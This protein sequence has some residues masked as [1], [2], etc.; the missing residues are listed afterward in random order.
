MKT[1][2]FALSAFWML[3]LASPRAEAES[4]RGSYA[5][6]AEVYEVLARCDVND[7]WETMGSYATNEEALDIVKYVRLLGCEAFI[8]THPQTP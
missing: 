4:F 7:P 8:K 1:V 2:L 6:A 3:G 5:Q